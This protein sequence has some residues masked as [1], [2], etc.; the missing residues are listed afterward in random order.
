MIVPHAYT[1]SRLVCLYCRSAASFPPTRLTA[2]PHGHVSQIKDDW[3]RF[4]L[5]TARGGFPFGDDGLRR[6]TN[7]RPRANCSGCSEEM[8][9]RERIAQVAQD[10]CATLSDLLRLLRG[11]E[12]LSD[13]LKKI[14]L[15]NL[16]SCFLVLVHPAHL[17][18][19]SQ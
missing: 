10:K 3:R 11:N 1:T 15:K 16:K 13:L 12:Q 7:E 4:T 19:G 9:V 2:P 17:Y 6:K 5:P 14:W 8:S 18:G